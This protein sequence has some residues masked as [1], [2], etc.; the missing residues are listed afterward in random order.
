MTTLQKNEIIKMREQGCGYAA[1]ANALC[2]SKDSV[3]TFC[4]RNGLTGVRAG[5]EKICGK[6]CPQCSKEIV[7][8]SKRKPRRFCS[9]KCRK[10][11]WNSH[12]E[13]VS[14]KAVY[15]FTCVGCGEPFKA[16]GNQHRK[17]CSH[18]CYVSTRFK[19]G[20]AV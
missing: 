12:P 10:T 15:S 13:K 14:Q 20:A 16:Y 2:I 6:Y 1:I 9:D 11:W 4:R 17:Y 18:E 8:V 19:G 3:K 5:K 7:Q